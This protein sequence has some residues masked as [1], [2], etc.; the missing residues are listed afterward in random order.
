MVHSCFNGV[1]S[2]ICNGPN[3][4]PSLVQVSVTLGLSSLSWKWLYG[5][6]VSDFAYICVYT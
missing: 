4:G 3:L 1:A 5:V 6:L 2:V